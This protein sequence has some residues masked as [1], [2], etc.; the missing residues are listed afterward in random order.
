MR[1][2]WVLSPE[3]GDIFPVLDDGSG[4]IEYGR[5]VVLVTAATKRQ[6]IV[7]GVRRMRADRQFCG[8]HRRYPDE[9]PFKGMKAYLE[10]AK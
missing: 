1:Q 5:D 9:N 2:W 4:P 10:E 7:E 3:W 6:A 8:Y